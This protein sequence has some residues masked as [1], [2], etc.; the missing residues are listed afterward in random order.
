MYRH[1]YSGSN[2]SPNSQSARLY[3]SNYFV[4]NKDFRVYICLQNGSHGP[5]ESLGSNLT[6]N[7]SQD[8]PTFT[9]LE[10]SPLE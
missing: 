6:G 10:P 1:D 9:D 4:V 5:I 7:N 3:D 8:E 2:K